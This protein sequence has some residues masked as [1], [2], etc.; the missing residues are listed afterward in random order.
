[1]RLPDETSAADV[2]RTIRSRLAGDHFGST[3][4]WPSDAATPCRRLAAS[5]D[6]TQSKYETTPIAEGTGWRAKADAEIPILA[7]NQAAQKTTP[8]I[9]LRAACHPIGSRRNPGLRSRTIE[10]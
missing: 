3:R 10:S 2:E 5:P 7:A 1:M 8:G 9:R 4:P 6:P